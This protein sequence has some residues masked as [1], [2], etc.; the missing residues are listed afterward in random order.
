ME[1]EQAKCQ[2]V[3]L[4]L[5]RTISLSPGQATGTINRLSKALIK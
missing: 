5:V 1:V 2:V 3:C 4:D